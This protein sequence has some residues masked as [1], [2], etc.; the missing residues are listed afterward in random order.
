MGFKVF[1]K[2]FHNVVVLCFLNHFFPPGFHFTVFSS[3][4]KTRKLLFFV[5]FLD[6]CL[7]FHSC[8]LRPL[9]TSGGGKMFFGGV[10]RRLTFFFPP[11]LT[12]TQFESFTWHLLLDTQQT[13]NLLAKI[14]DFQAWN[15]HKFRMAGMAKDPASPRIAIDHVCHCV[16][17]LFKQLQVIVKSTFKVSWKL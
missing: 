1:R 17:Y 7:A 11:S 4:G 2:M 8:R 6:F 13:Q 3:G 15:W 16:E 14:F 5:R 9:K 10:L 12:S